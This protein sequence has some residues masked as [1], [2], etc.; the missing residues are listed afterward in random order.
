MAEEIGEEHASATF[1]LLL[2]RGDLGS[3]LHHLCS[4]LDDVDRHFEVDI[5]GVCE[6]T[7]KDG[8]IE[9]DRWGHRWTK[10]VRIASVED[11]NVLLTITVVDRLGVR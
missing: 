4:V 3:G 2:N 5:V 7:C 1:A 10:P 8:V 11:G 9:L 6:E